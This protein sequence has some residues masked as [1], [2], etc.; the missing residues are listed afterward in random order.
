MSDVVQVWFLIFYLFLKLIFCNLFIKR[1]WLYIIWE[2]NKYN[3]NGSDKEK[4]LVI[5]GQ[6]LWGEMTFT[7]KDRY[8]NQVQCSNHL[9]YSCLL[10]LLNQV[11]VYSSN[12]ISVSNNSLIYSCLYPD[13]FLHVCMR[14]R[15]WNITFIC[16]FCWTHYKNYFKLQSHTFKY[17]KYFE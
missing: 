4:K 8:L 9:K 15:K 14:D 11:K 2:E 5:F 10:L 6:V 7:F 17:Y 1:I 13:L 3:N 12:I 16:P